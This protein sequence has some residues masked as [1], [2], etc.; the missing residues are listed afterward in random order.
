MRTTV[1]R[2]L[3]LALI[4]PRAIL[5]HALDDSAVIYLLDDTPLDTT[6]PEQPDTAALVGH[7]SRHLGP[8][9]LLFG[10][11]HE[12]R[13]VYQSIQSPNTTIRFSP[14][15]GWRVTDVKDQDTK[16]YMTVKAFNART[17]DEIP[18][19]LVWRAAL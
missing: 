4:T 19:D 11:T 7:L 9:R 6:R 2:L 13:P 18:A 15:A 16:S 3:L 17:P 5:G 8:Y 10:E 12:G 1:N 14:S